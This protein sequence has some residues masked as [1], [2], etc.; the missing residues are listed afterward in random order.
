MSPKGH[1]VV[2]PEG[3]TIVGNFGVGQGLPAMDSQATQ[4][5]V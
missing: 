4:A 5:Y 3:T 2:Y 1:R